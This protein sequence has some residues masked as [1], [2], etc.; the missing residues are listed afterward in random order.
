MC[1]GALP[2]GTPAADLSAADLSAPHL[3]VADLSAP[4]LSV[5]DLSAP[6]LSVADLSAPHLSVADLSAA[7]RHAGIRS[8]FRHSDPVDTGRLPQEAAFT[9]QG[10]APN[11][12]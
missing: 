11:K 5:A 7:Q 12:E 2:P 8:N 1:G 9:L 10:V 6:H 4:H 3:S